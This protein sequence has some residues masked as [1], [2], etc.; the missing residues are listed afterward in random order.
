MIRKK[1]L[2]DAGIARLRPAEREYTVWDT[3][4]PGLGVRVRPSGHRGYVY[5]GEREGL[6]KRLTLGPVALKRVEDV[7]RECLAVRK[8]GS[9]RNPAPLF[10]DYVAG[11]WRA[12]CYERYKPST[13]K[14][15]AS[16]LK[17]QLL[18]TFG[19][20]PLDRITRTAVHRWFDDYS[21]SAPGAANDRLKTLRQILNHAIT[22]GY[23]ETNP[24][25]GV[26]M[27]PRPKLTRFLS[28]HEVH[29]LHR[30]LDGYATGARGRQADIIR[31]LLLTGCRKSE[32]KN[33]RWTEVD[34]DVLNLTDSKTGP[35]Q[36]LLN[37][38]ARRIIQCQTRGTSAF[39]FPSPRDPA[40]PLSGDIA[41]WYSVRRQAGVE[42]VRL[43]DLRHTVAS[44][45][46]LQGVPLAVIS[47][48]L[49]H[50]QV[51]MTLRYAHVSDTEVEAA[52]E[53]IG[54]AIA[55]LM[56]GGQSDRSR[57]CSAADPPEAPTAAPAHTADHQER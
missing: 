37:R 38:Q 35:R 10:R 46:A 12:A 54:L 30:A 34:G 57:D 25:R 48:M 7:R 36:V 43:H 50:S 51:Q 41:L 3:R 32:I 19:S 9:P 15:V 40:R 14:T 1:R 26:K 13:R 39:V 28:K 47:K 42:D 8:P 24:A 44:Q 21:Q 6:T 27:N 56:K 17:A 16:S 53:R 52:A 33:L 4:L 22:H 2:T 49:G 29:R 55:R 45:A 18:P 31:L 5:Y 20:L 11:K 23:L